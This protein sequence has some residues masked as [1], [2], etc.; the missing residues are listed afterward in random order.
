[1]TSRSLNTRVIRAAPSGNCP[2]TACARPPPNGSSPARSTTCSPPSPAA[3]SPARPCGNWPPDRPGPQATTQDPHKEAHGTSR[4]AT[5][6]KK[7]RP[8]PSRNRQPSLTGDS[9]TGRWVFSRAFRRRMR[10]GGKPGL[11]R[12][13]SKMSAGS[14]YLSIACPQRPPARLRVT[15]TSAN[16]QRGPSCDREQ[17]NYLASQTLTRPVTLPSPQEPAD[18]R[19]RAVRGA[20]MT[21]TPLRP[22]R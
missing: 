5:H 17:D 22:P 3:T 19:P 14:A 6:A 4:P 8:Q 2:C 15:A 13:S 16:A 10:R 18:K 21:Q 12:E 11:C 7:G 20:A 1:M 9:A